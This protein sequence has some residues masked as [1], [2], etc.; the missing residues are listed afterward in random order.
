MPDAICLAIRPVARCLLLAWVRSD[1]PRLDFGGHK[2]SFWAAKQKVAAHARTLLRG[3][4]VIGVYTSAF[5]EL[6]FRPGVSVA[7]S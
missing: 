6:V 3:K 4:K 5:L 2:L 7:A 1:H